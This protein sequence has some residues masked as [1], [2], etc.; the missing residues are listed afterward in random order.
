MLANG[1][2]ELNGCER[3]LDPGD[4]GRSSRKGLSS[5][6]GLNGRPYG[7]SVVPP[8]GPLALDVALALVWGGGAPFIVGEGRTPGNAGP[9]S[10]ME[11]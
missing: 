5:L 7:G 2:A 3:K 10:C 8:A 6:G 4:C 1:G 11:I 9:L